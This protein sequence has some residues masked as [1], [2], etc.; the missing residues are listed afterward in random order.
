MGRRE[1]LFI[2]GWVT[3]FVV[4][5]LVNVPLYLEGIIVEFMG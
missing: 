4:F 2:F 3:V 5:R 1:L